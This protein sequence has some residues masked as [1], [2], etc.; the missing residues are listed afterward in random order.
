MK[1][2]Y[3]KITKMTWVY[4]PTNVAK[5]LNITKGDEVEFLKLDSANT[6]ETMFS[7]KKKIKTN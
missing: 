2:Q 5:L 6:A 3:N 1:V 7:M 4:I